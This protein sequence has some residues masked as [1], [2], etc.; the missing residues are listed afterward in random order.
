MDVFF[1][2]IRLIAIRRG[3]AARAF[4][5]TMM[6][7]SAACAI[8]VPNALLKLRFPCSHLAPPYPGVITI[9]GAF[10]KHA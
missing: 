9:I 1:R 2:E 8:C 7:I 4:F 3:S 6:A 10:G 5:P